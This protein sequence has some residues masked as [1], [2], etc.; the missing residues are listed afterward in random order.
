[1]P[2]VTLSRRRRSA[3]P[4][5][6][7]SGAD[8][9]LLRLREHPVI[10]YESTPGEL[11]VE[12]AVR[13]RPALAL[14]PFRSASLARV[15]L[16]VIAYPGAERLLFVRGRP[17]AGPPWLAV[18]RG[19]QQL[20]FGESE[21]VLEEG[22]PLEPATA[23]SVEPAPC[24]LDRI[25]LRARPAARCPG[26]GLTLHR[27]CWERVLGL[28]PEAPGCPACKLRLAREGP[29]AGST[30]DGEQSGGAEFRLEVTRA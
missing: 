13:A 5:G 8:P 3:P 25:P 2:V 30:R 4:S 17:L 29:A 9:V 10:L 24:R 11:G 28:T 1:M 18:W 7:R 14:V 6:P 22:E 21:L 16:A 15:A 23:E 12:P 20:L 19:G 27:D 26:C